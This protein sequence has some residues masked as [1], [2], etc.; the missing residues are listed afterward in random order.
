MRSITLAEHTEFDT[1]RLIRRIPF[2]NNIYE[3]SPIEFEALVSLSDIVYAEPGETIISQGDT[4]MYTY[5]LLKGQL[6]VYLDD[7][8]DSLP[9]NQISPGEVFG[10]LSMMTQTPRSAYIRTD[11]KSKT[12]LLF[13]LDYGHITDASDCS[14]LNL[15]T[16]LIFY[17]MALH[18]IRWTLEM[19]KMSDP[20]HYLVEKIRKLPFVNAPKGTKEELDALKKQAHDLS[21]ILFEWNSSKTDD[22]S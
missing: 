16:K 14:K 1:E 19:N 3:A 13:R 17:R 6:G 22:A 5:F 11:A 2:F 21:D 18:N 12:S 7:D 8:P 4:D 20:N 10:I 9:I 15:E